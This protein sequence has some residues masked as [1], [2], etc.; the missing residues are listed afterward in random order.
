MTNFKIHS[1]GEHNGKTVQV[2]ANVK[3]TSALDA[4]KAY[5]DSVVRH[6]INLKSLTLKEDVKD[7]ETNG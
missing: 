1:Q 5:L 2:Y 4:L 6:N 3:S 7:S